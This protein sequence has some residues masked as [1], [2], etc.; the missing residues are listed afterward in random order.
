MSDKI[1]LSPEVLAAITAADK[2][3]APEQSFILTSKTYF[4]QT[5]LR[6]EENTLVEGA[7]PEGFPRFIAHGVVVVEL[8][9]PPGAALPPGAKKPTHR[10]PIQVPVAGNTIQEAFANAPAALDA[11]AQS[12]QEQFEAHHKD[13]AAKGQLR[14]KL[15]QGIIKP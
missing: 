3:A 6:I 14:K 4:N 1:Q 7:F 11:E 15:T 8:P 9:L 5:G 2:P 12:F 13:Q 10:Q